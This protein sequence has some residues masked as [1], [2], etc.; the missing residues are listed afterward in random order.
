MLCVL[1]DSK[2]DFVNVQ[3]VLCGTT[4]LIQNDFD[5]YEMDIYRGLKVALYALLIT[6]V[7]KY[8]LVFH[9]NMSVH[10]HSR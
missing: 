2:W 8:S 10:A 4:T 1:F 5:Y 6:S 3:C 9:N 7:L